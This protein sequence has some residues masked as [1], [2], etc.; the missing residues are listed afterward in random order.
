MKMLFAKLV[1]SLVATVSYVQSNT[2]YYKQYG[3]FTGS[4]TTNPNYGGGSMTTYYDKYSRSIGSS[5]R[6]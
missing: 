5:N 3:S 2:N 1:V 4:F 6:R